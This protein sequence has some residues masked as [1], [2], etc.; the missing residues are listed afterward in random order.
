MV[1]GKPL[2]PST[3]NTAYQQRALEQEFS[4][5]GIRIEWSFPSNYTVNETYARGLPDFTN[6]GPIHA[7]AA[8]APGSTTSC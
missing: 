2:M 3:L 7:L 1:G 5:D 4:R 8:R 6:M